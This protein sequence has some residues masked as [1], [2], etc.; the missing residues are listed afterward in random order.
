MRTLIRLALPL[1]LLTAACSRTTQLD[2]RTFPLQYLS[3]D[4]VHGLIEP[5]VFTD[6]AGAPG[7]LSFTESTV[8]VRETTDNL[9]KIARVLTQ[10]DVPSPWVR[11]HFQLIEADGASAPDSSIAAVE[12]E[13][14]KLF[15]YQGY[16]LESEA[17]VSGTAR[18]HIEQVIGGQPRTG[19]GYM[20]AVDV[21]EIRM[22][23]DSGFVSLQVHL[24]SPYGGAL[25][26]RINARAGQ[27]VVLGNAQLD[28]HGNTKILT[29]R[30]E[31][32]TQ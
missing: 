20:L 18:S 13:L 21:G 1:V 31:L 29:V 14:R 23:G 6:R 7:S 12:T 32:V 15:R 26:T 8:T 30:P 22:I 27:T 16:K 2:T 24:R 10:Y 11:L 17:V 4:A 19:S 25:A 5:Y 3:A 28:E 9:D